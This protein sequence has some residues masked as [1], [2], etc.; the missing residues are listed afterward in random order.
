[1][2]LQPGYKNLLEEIRSNTLDKRIF[3]RCS[4]IISLDAGLG[5]EAMAISM[6]IGLRSVHIYIRAF[7]KSGVDGL[8]EFN[9]RGRQQRLDDHEVDCLKKE[10][11]QN[12][13]VSREQIQSYILSEWGI[14]YT[15]SGVR[16][17]L[18]RIGYVYKKTKTVPGK[19]NAG[20][21]EQV[22]IDMEEVFADINDD[23][24]V[25]YYLDGCHPTHNTHPAYGWIR[26]GKDDTIKGNT[27]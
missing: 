15:R 9:Y 26:Q 4:V 6:N 20:D 24:E 27:G 14:E 7:E 8:L 25:V 13:Y 19:A 17:L 1:M 22:V 3:V 11:D 18:H 12:L 2:K 21:Q 16:D 5:D 10:L 23:E